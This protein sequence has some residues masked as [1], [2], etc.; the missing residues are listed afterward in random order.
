MKSNGKIFF[1][2]CLNAYVVDVAP[3]A[4][5]SAGLKQAQGVTSAANQSFARISYNIVYMYCAAI[6]A[7]KANS[8]KSSVGIGVADYASAP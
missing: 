4:Q 2:L 6:D 5:K 3:G 1:T 8:A 7:R